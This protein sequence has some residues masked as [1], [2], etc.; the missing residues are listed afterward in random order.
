MRMRTLTLA[1]LCQLVL[2]AGASAQ[3]HFDDPAI[4]PAHPTA[5]QPVAARVQI[6][7]CEDVPIAVERIGTTITLWHEPAGCPLLP[8]VFEQDVPLGVLPEGTYVV[9]IYVV[10]H[11]DDVRL[12]DEAVFAVGSAAC[13]GDGLCLAQ[14][15]FAVTADWRTSDGQFGGGQPRP[16]S[17][18]SGTFWFFHPENTELVVKVIDACSYNGRRW[19]YAAG[20]TDVE[21][22]L[23]VRDEATGAVKTYTNPQGRPFQP[24]VD[25]DAF[26]CIE[27]PHS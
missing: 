13:A 20:L 27:N 22:T 5:D 1:A 9:R 10:G 2:A 24:I 19:V 18:A 11:P 6:A 12:E 7:A 23:R 26:D 17:D 14:G 25:S 21:V 8:P 4:V 15:R 16:L 3:V